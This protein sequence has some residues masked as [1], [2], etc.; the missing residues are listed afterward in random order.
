VFVHISAVHR[1]GLDTLNEGAKVSY[2]LIA[3]RGKESAENLRLG[4][5]WLLPW[6]RVLRC[7]CRQRASLQQLEPL[8]LFEGFPLGNPEEPIL[9]PVSDRSCRILPILWTRRTGTNYV[10]PVIGKGNTLGGLGAKPRPGAIYGWASNAYAAKTATLAKPRMAA[11]RSITTWPRFG[12]SPRG[13]CCAFDPKVDRVRIASWYPPCCGLEDRGVFVSA[14]FRRLLKMVSLPPLAQV[15]G[16]Q[17]W[18][19]GSSCRPVARM[20]RSCWKLSWSCWAFAAA[21]WFSLHSGAL[22]W[23]A[24]SG[25]DAVREWVWSAADRLSHLRGPSADRLRLTGQPARESRCS[26]AVWGSSSP[27][28]APGMQAI[29]APSQLLSSPQSDFISD[30]RADFGT[31]GH[32]PASG[33]ACG[34]KSRLGDKT[35]LSLGH[36]S[37]QARSAASSRLAKPSRVWLAPTGTYSSAAGIPITALSWRKP[38]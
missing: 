12:R 15:S 28:L 24:Q 34:R 22:R 25:A 19:R 13:T 5:F 17:G 20:I 14:V 10:V 11:A 29:D 26:L 36:G 7:L 33:P 30:R 21:R 3:N 35:R 18:H 8:S 4:W 31:E 9:C 16:W 27:Q 32:R 37:P 23:S 1:A 6:H 2:E 38:G